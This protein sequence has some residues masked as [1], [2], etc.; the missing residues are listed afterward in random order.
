MER[1]QPESTVHEEYQEVHST[2]SR[3]KS[4]N[5]FIHPN[6]AHQQCFGSDLPLSSYFVAWT[7]HNQMQMGAIKIFLNQTS[8]GDL[9][10]LYASIAFLPIRRISVNRLPVPPPSHP[11][12]A[13]RYVGF[14]LGKDPKAQPEDARS[15]FKVC[16]EALNLNNWTPHMGKRD[17]M[18]PIKL[19]RLGAIA[20][21]APTVVM[22]LERSMV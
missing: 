12:Y 15:Q 7:I 22:P 5:V 2:P 1:F 17:L 4:K 3:S 8:Q 18:D 10:I 9:I 20:S 11:K 21:F 19:Q 14:I 16:N 6:M 13:Y